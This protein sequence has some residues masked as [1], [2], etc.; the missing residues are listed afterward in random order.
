M[1][2]SLTGNGAVGEILVSSAVRDLTAGSG[3]IFED[4]GIHD[5]KGIPEPWHL[6]A[7]NGS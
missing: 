4:R 5:L 3:I 7:V 2:S 6:Y 1:P